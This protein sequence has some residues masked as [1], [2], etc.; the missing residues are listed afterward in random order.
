MLIK[1]KYK[2]L[3]VQSSDMR[4][5]VKFFEFKGSSGP[6]PTQDFKKVLFECYAEIYNSSMKD[7]ELL[8][9]TITKRVVTINIRDTQGQYL[10]D[11]KHK[12][13]I[14]DHRYSGVVWEIMDVSYS[15]DR[16][17]VKLIL[18]VVQ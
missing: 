5:P 15:N 8:K 12:V 7:L 17:F 14:V 10:P 4:T 3:S 9:N 2:P 13:E 11:N 18:G 6:D 16:R 1:F